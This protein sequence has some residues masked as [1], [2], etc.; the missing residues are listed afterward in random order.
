M[1]RNGDKVSIRGDYQFKAILSTNSVQK[2]WHLN[3]FKT[4]DTFLPPL[5]SNNV[6]DIG[7]GSGV[8]SDY[9]AEKAELVIGV[10]GNINAIEF[11]KKKFI[12][13][14]LVFQHCLVD[15]NYGLEASFDKIYCF[16]LIEHIY[17]EQSVIMLDNFFR[18][19]KY[20][21]KVL[22]TTPNYRSFWPIIEFIMD[23]FNLAPRMNGDQHV[24][25]FNKNKL[26]KLAYDTNFDIIS[27]HT[28]NLMAP[29]LSGINYKIA[30]KINNFE[31]KLQHFGLT[32]VLILTKKN[33][34]NSNVSIT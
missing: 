12:K 9:L 1:R 27:Y 30:E 22:I 6:L 25:H 17:Y 32:S 8:V 14:N 7:C 10:D 33:T 3:K 19:L 5:K 15:E 21:G 20:E 4:I 24:E 16:E 28:I 11:A 23:N 31:F 18:L 26:F 2:F 13:E 34:N 29:W